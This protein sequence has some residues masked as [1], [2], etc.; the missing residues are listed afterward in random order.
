M[1]PG[2]RHSHS[3]DE[4]LRLV[5][6]RLKGYR[7]PSLGKPCCTM[8]SEKFA[9]TQT[10]CRVAWN[11]LFPTHTPSHEPRF[12]TQPPIAPYSNA[13]S[14]A[15]IRREF[16]VWIER[17]SASPYSNANSFSTHPTIL[18]Q[19][20]D[21]WQAST[22]SARTELNT[23]PCQINSQ[24]RTT[25][26]LPPLICHETRNPAFSNSSNAR[27]TALRRLSDRLMVRSAARWIS[28]RESGRGCW[29]LAR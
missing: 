10:P 13:Y 11:I 21:A 5:I 20:E 7:P 29:W 8:V 25:A 16:C 14:A 22:G 3:D 9:P 28:L 1:L 26:M 23:S 6:N 24:R 4:P 15:V 19:P 17:F 12:P 18:M 2:E 27:T